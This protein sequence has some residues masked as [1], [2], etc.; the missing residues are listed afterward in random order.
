MILTGSVALV[1]G[2]RARMAAKEIM[3]MA[4]RRARRARRAMGKATVMKRGISRWEQGP[5]CR[6]WGSYSYNA[7]SAQNNVILFQDALGVLKAWGALWGLVGSCRDC[8]KK[9]AR[10]MQALLFEVLKGATKSPSCTAAVP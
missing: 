10:I 5:V 2:V 3:A 9:L 1:R 8:D 6:L 4:A 7:S